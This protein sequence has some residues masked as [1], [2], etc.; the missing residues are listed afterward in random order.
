MF[1]GKIKFNYYWPQ[2]SEKPLG[3]ALKYKVGTNELLY[4]QSIRSFLR[5]QNGKL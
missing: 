4:T 1:K 3:K 5:G 2:E